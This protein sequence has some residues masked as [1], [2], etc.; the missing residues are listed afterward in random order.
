MHSALLAHYKTTSTVQKREAKKNSE[1]F[2]LQYIHNGVK[3]NLIPF[4]Q[5]LN[6]L[7]FVAIF[8]M[9]DL[10]LKNVGVLNRYSKFRKEVNVDFSKALTK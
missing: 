8:S 6:H 3:S 7:H 1:H 9:F 4:L 5:I 10:E 2:G